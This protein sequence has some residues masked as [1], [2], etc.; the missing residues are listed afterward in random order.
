MSARSLAAR[1]ALCLLVCFAEA[2]PLL[3]VPFTLAAVGHGPDHRQPA[4][5]PR[6]ARRPSRRRREA[7]RPEVADARPG[8]DR[9]CGPLAASVPAELCE[10]VDRALTWDVP[11]RYLLL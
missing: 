8:D 6:R 2:A 10:A 7:D 3:A 4:R 9:P 11:R 1:A 5:R